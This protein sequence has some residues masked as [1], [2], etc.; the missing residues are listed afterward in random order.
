MRLPPLNIEFYNRPAD[1]VAPELLGKL[2]VCRHKQQ[3]CVGRIVE[4]EAY[5]SQHDAACHAARGKTRKNASMF[6]APG[7]AYV[8]MI[9]ARWCFNAV[10]EPEGI[11]SA[12]LIRAVEPMLGIAYMQ[13]RRQREKLVDLTSGPAK[14]CQA[15]EINQ[16]HDSWNLTRGQKIWLADD[17]EPVAIPATI[18]TTTRIGISLAQELPLRYY[19]LN[20]AFVSVKKRNQG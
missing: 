3:F 5:L 14:L 2:L 8:Y 20:N 15:F 1:I 12:V 11:P 13:Q 18:V 19:Y 10:T 7:T 16:S 9:H 4:T 17:P 6:G